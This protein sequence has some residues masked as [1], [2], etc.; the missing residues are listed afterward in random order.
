[1][2]FRSFVLFNE[3]TKEILTVRNYP[4]MLHIEVKALDEDTVV[5]SSPGFD[6]FVVKVPTK[7]KNNTKMV[8]M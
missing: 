4:Q 2:C 1:M 5:F 8:A 3:R 6:D 7:I